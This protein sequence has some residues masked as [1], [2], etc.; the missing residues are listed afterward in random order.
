MKS[1][2]QAYL[3]MLF[4]ST[5]KKKK[6]WKVWCLKLC[7][8]LFAIPPSNASNMKVSYLVVVFDPIPEN[9]YL[10]HLYLVMHF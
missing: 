9:A 8:F 4:S 7:L 2:D 10:L 5:I 3:E 1:F 6:V